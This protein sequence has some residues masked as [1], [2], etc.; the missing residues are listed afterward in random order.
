VVFD[1]KSVE[2]FIGFSSKFAILAKIMMEEEMIAYQQIVSSFV[3]QS[4]EE[5][6]K[7]FLKTQPNLIKRIPQHQIAT[8]L[9]V[10]PETLSRI[11][12][13]IMKR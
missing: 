8:F 3:T 4:A 9:G 6:Y 11:R 2:N 1:S 10:S 7:D 13:R 12:N 5:R